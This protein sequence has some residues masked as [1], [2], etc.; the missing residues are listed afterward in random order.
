M[1]LA[2]P[3]LLQPGDCVRVVAPS[4]P[5]PEPRFMAGLARLQSR[6]NVRFDPK[7]VFAQQ[8]YLAGSDWQRAE[9]MHAAATEPDTKAIWMARGGYG[10]MRILPQLPWEVLRASPK[11]LVGFSDGTALLAALAA[12]SGLGSVHGPVVTQLD[13]LPDADLEHLWRILEAPRQGVVLEG[14]TALV[15]GIAE[16]PLLGG[17]LEVLSRLLATPYLPDLS[18]AILFIEDVGERPYRV[19][20]LLT[21]LELSGILSRIAGALVGEFVHC[22]EPPSETNHSPGVQEVVAERLGRFGFPVAVGGLF[23]HG[24]R[25]LA[26]PFGTRVRLQAGE[27][28]LTYA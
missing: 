1:T 18:G 6:Y 3:P 25:H 22:I 13:E 4:G 8:G 17:N 14:L 23:G 2:Q 15:A 21:Q 26:L 7:V 11:T 20:R 27:G 19:D 10:L 9:A 5:V 28:V 24:K 16:G 12:Q